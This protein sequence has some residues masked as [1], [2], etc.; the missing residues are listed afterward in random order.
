MSGPIALGMAPSAAV[1]EPSAPAPHEGAC[2]VFPASNP[3]N[4]DISRAPVAPNSGKYVQSIGASIHLHADFGTPPSYGIPYVVVG[5]HQPKVPIRFTEYGEESNPGPYPVPA[6]APVEGAGEEGDRHVLVLQEGTCKLYELYN[7]ERHGAGWD[8]GSGAVF[9]LR[10]NALRPEGWTSADA[11]GLPIFPLLVRYPEVKAGRIDHALRVTVERTQRGY[12]HPATHFASASSDPNLP[13][14]GLRLRLK[15][16]F[17]LL[18]Y[19]GEALVVLRALKRYGLIVADNGS[20]W[21]IT[22]APDPHW[23]D[24][25]LNQLKRVPGSAFE[26]VRTGPILRRG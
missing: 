25:D 11:A 26:A 4:Q 22:G 6:N 17:S 24:E 13:P 21:Y 12:I 3:L 7:A 8:A 9:N 14:M 1:P 15:A 20:S 5:V 19:H 2:P 18:G 10:G 16:S 23:S